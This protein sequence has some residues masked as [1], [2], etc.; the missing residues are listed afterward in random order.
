MLEREIERGEVEG[1][2]EQ[3][4]RGNRKGRARDERKRGERVGER[5]KGEG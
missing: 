4:C 1:K 3:R 2:R 5:D